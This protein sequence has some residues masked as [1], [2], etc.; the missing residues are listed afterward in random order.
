MSAHLCAFAQCRSNWPP[1]GTWHL[2]QHPLLQ[3]R[4]EQ[5][6]SLSSMT[7]HHSS[8]IL[9][10]HYEVTVVVVVPCRDQHASTLRLLVISEMAHSPAHLQ[11]GEA[12]RESY[13]LSG[14]S[15]RILSEL[16]LT[17]WREDVAQVICCE[18]P[19]NC[20]KITKGQKKKKTKEKKEEKESRE[21]GARV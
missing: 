15:I 2:R 11:E 12:T 20:H 13:S 3:N 4:P 10:I 9:A 1:N 8:P 6:A 18:Q 17:R 7:K 19:S 16:S 14:V 21:K 5:T